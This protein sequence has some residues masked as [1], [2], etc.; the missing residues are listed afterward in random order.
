MLRNIGLLFILAI[1]TADN[2]PKHCICSQNSATCNSTNLASFGERIFK[3]KITNPKVPLIIKNGH[4]NVSGLQD[5]NSISIEYATI[6]DIDDTAFSGI[7]KLSSFS[8]INS[9]IPLINP[10]T[11]SN[12][13]NLRILQIS[14]STLKK[15]DSFKSKSLEELDLS[16]NRLTTIFKTSFEFLTSLTFINLENNNISTIDPLAFSNLINLQDVLLSNNNIKYLD[17]N[18]FEKNTELI[19]IN[20]S[21]NPLKQINLNL[22]AELE[23]LTL[24]SCQLR[25]FDEVLSKNLGLLSYLDLSGN[26][27]ELTSNTFTKMEELEFIDLSRNNLTSLPSRIFYSNYKLQRINLDNNRFKDFPKFESNHNFQTYYFSCSNCSIVRLDEDSFKYFPSLVILNL[28]RNKIIGA[29]LTAIQSLYRLVELNLSYNNIS[30]IHPSSFIKSAALQTVNLAGNPLK[31]INPNVFYSNRFL[32]YLDVSNCSLKKLWQQ[33]VKKNLDFLSEL[34]VENNL[35]TSISPRDLQ[36]V[37]VINILGISQNLLHCDEVLRDAITWLTKHQVLPR[38]AQTKT[39]E[40]IVNAN[41][42]ETMLNQS[43]WRVLIKE[44]C[45]DEFYFENSENE[46]KVIAENDQNHI[47]IEPN[48]D[49]NEEDSYWYNDDEYS[50]MDEDYVKAKSLFESIRFKSESH[51]KYSFLWPTLVFIFTALSVLVIAANVLLLILKTRALPRNVNLPH[52]KIPRWN[53]NNRLK[54]HSGSVYQPLSEE[55]TD[56]FVPN[57]KVEVPT[58]STPKSSV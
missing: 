55:R 38:S 21:N 44:R 53:S 46:L 2:C 49:D 56:I 16:G 45:L 39:H 36:V 42:T 28:S 14:N 26:N 27:L 3:L 34:N 47:E 33:P 20:L 24:K 9:N 37:P 13:K 41:A 15:F 29:N 40:N 54:K 35:L 57:R 23:K 18:I 31:V 51:T 50:K 4:F 11:F 10:L 6:I 12:T 8:M 25:S 32:K 52:I 22:T 48:V 7:R 19:N 1:A 30:V 5:V 58:H 17:P 43:S